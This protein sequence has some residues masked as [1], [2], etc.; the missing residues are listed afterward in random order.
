MAVLITVT[1]LLQVPAG[2]VFIL[3][4]DSI[5][6]CY[7]CAVLVLHLSQLRF[8]CHNSVSILKK[9]RMHLNSSPCVK[10]YPALKHVLIC[11]KFALFWD[12]ESVSAV[13]SIVQKLDSG[14]TVSIVLNCIKLDHIWNWLENPC[15]QQWAGRHF[16]FLWCL[17][18][19]GLFVEMSHLCC[20]LYQPSCI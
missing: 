5:L 16:C 2:E 11:R 4:A 1:I 6:P 20:N 3:F 8:S 18:S 19:F 15:F 9:L 14:N 10:F 13:F 12:L 7:G 17:F